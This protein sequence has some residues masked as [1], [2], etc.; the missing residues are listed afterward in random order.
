ME[1]DKTLTLYKFTN[2]PDSQYL[3]DLLAIFYRGVDANTVG[4]MAAFNVETEEE[5][6]I[7]VGIQLDQDNKP[8]CF[9]LAKVLKHEDVL[10]YLAPD[11]KGGYFDMTNPEEVAASKEN[12]VA[13]PR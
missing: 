13:A 2:H 9:P 6:L 12:M 5:E 10:N 1:Q 8:E 11:G 7:L 3:D 4:V